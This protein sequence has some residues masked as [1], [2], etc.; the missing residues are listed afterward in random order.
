MRRA[1][2][3]LAFAASGLGCA[4]TQPA[5]PPA[6]AASAE[7]PL[8]APRC[9]LDPEVADYKRDTILT[10][11]GYVGSRS[12]RLPVVLELDSR[13]RIESVCLEEG[14]S[15]DRETRQQLER[16]IRTL[17][18]MRPGPACLAGTR[19]ELAEDFADAGARWRPRTPAIP[20]TDELCAMGQQRCTGWREPVC[21]LFSD[22]RRATYPDACEACLAAGVRGYDEGPCPIYP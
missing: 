1:I 6:C 3:L 9:E 7:R 22:G 14:G 19:L 20:R 12:S 15:L 21:A 8:P 5:A 2:R 10:L 17:R 13:A 11:W 18:A 4:G 16:A